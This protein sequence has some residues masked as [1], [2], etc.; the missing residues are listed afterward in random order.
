MLR[1]RP[2]DPTPP[3][4]VSC[5]CRLIQVEAVFAAPDYG[6]LGAHLV[7]HAAPLPFKEW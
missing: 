6:R 4:S 1:N 2:R 3:H 7:R 5:G